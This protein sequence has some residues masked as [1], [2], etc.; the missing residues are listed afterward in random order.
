MLENEDRTFGLAAI[1]PLARGLG[2]PVAWDAHHHRCHD[3]EGIPEHEALTMALATWP[4]G[5]RPKIHYSSPRT[6]LEEVVRREGRRVVRTPRVPSFR[7]HADLIDP[8]DF[9][10]FL[11]DSLRGPIVDVML[12]AKGK[13]L[14][15]LSLRERLR[16]A[17]H[18]VAAAAA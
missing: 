8:L 16:A 13:D 10:R 18:P 17:G 3:P 11:R 9:A 15:L 12:E 7:S 4:E 5:V 6:A 1:E 2:V 14:A